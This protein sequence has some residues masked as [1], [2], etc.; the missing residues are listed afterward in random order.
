MRHQ[1][2]SVAKE[3]T[4]GRHYTLKSPSRTVQ[5]FDPTRTA[6]R[7]I[8]KTTPNCASWAKMA[9]G[10][11]IGS[12]RHRRHIYNGCPNPATA[13]FKPG[14]WPRKPASTQPPVLSEL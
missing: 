13:V 5:P 8:A 14:H 7:E 1:N 3:N 2:P 6:S 10:L 4:Q 12:S 11:I 9:I